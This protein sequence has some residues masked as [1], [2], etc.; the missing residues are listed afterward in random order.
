MPQLP[1]ACLLH[2]PTAYLTPFQHS[3]SRPK[4]RRQ[5]YRRWRAAPTPAA[6]LLQAPATYLYARQ[7]QLNV[8]KQLHEELLD[9]STALTSTGAWRTLARAADCTWVCMAAV[10]AAAA[11]V[12]F[13]MQGGQRGT[14]GIQL[15]TGHQPP[16][17]I[18]QIGICLN[19]LASCCC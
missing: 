6:S 3:C 12:A 16:A 11:A 17:V 19:S 8:L 15:A 13:P 7:L 18:R 2:E 9:R 14:S 4:V 1:G 10:A 5:G